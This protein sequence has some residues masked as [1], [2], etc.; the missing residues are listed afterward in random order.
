MA[1]LTP[2]RIPPSICLRSIMS[3]TTLVSISAP[4]ST[5]LEKIAL[6][7]LIWIAIELVQGNRVTEEVVDPE[8]QDTMV[9]D[10]SLAHAPKKTGDAPATNVSKAPHVSSVCC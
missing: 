5:E 3:V 9:Q 10:A 6:S 4:N 7:L 2:K 1:I 8:T